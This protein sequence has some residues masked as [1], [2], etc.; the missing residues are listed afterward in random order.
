MFPKVAF[1][2]RGAPWALLLASAAVLAA[3]CG[4]DPPEAQTSPEDA[5]GEA[6]LILTWT[7]EDP[8]W[9]N[10]W[11]L[12]RADGRI[13]YLLEPPGIRTEATL[14]PGEIQELRR[15]LREAQVCQMRSRRGGEDGESR[16]RLTLNLAQQRCDVSLYYGEWRGSA[17]HG[18]IE[19]LRRRMR[20]ESASPSPA[21][22]LQRTP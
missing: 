21:Q 14:N 16:P 17:I 13:R 10:E 9:G 11:L 8:R 5:P 19:S 7:I 22:P 1:V 4:D 6:P 2:I 20:Q 12:V 18:T 3:G 15:E